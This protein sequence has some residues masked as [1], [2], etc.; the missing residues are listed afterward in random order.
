[1]GPAKEAAQFFQNLGKPCPPLYNPADHY[2]QVLAIMP[3]SRNE[4]LQK[5]NVCL[6]NKL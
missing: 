6:Y 5:V 4:C 1:M 2:I 3:N